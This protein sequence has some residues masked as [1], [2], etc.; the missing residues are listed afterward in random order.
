MK[1]ENRFAARMLRF[2]APASLA[3]AIMATA[4]NFYPFEGYKVSAA[5]VKSGLAS[6]APDGTPTCDCTSSANHNCACIVPC[7]PGSGGGG[8]APVTGP[9]GN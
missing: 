1:L 2:L 6:Y 3:L 9:G 4:L 5:C 7:P 8:L